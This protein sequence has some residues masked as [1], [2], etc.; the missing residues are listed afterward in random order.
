M[1][2]DAGKPE[3]VEGG[4]LF[5]DEHE[6]CEYAQRKTGKLKKKRKHTRNPKRVKL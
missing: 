4:M 6:D 1:K 2:H 3:Q 5:I